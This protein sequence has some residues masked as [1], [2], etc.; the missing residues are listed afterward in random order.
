MAAH[1][2]E[3]NVSHYL[4]TYQLFP[5]NPQATGPETRSL[6]QICRDVDSQIQAQKKRF[7]EGSPDPRRLAGDPKKARSELSLNLQAGG[8]GAPP[9]DKKG[10]QLGNFEDFR[11]GRATE[12]KTE[13]KLRSL[14]SRGWST[15][16]GTGGTSLQRLKTEESGGPKPGRGPPTRDVGAASHLKL[17]SIKRDLVKLYSDP[18]QASQ[19]A[20]RGPRPGRDFKL[21]DIS[22]QQTLT[23]EAEILS[24]LNSRAG[25][26]PDNTIGLGAGHT[27]SEA[28]HET[29]VELF[30]KWRPRSWF[31]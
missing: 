14:A 13:R 17:F 11:I 21:K 23:G 28:S 27:Q 22:H 7:R 10:L 19:Q 6:T 1:S 15:E 8:A 4:L 26:R 3:N 24:K 5:K 29:F 20:E 25:L 2:S 31:S 9:R 12:A 30:F 16:R 18:S